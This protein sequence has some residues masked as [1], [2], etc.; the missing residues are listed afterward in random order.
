VEDMRKAE[1]SQKKKKVYE[2]PEEYPTVV[3]SKWR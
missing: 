2:K 3:H 1:S